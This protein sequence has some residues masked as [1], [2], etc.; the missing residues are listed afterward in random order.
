MAA[1]LG[2][3]RLVT[4][5]FIYCLSSICKPGFWVQSHLIIDCPPEFTVHSS[6]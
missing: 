5:S 3:N 6:F 2:Y 4:L 1:W